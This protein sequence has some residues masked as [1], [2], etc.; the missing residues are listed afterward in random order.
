MRARGYIGKQSRR[1]RRR[2]PRSTMANPQQIPEK[3]TAIMIAE[4]GG[5]LVLRPGRIALP[6]PG[7]GEVL[8]RVRAAGVNRPDVRQRT[9]AHA[10]SRG[11]S[12]LPGLEASGEIVAL[13]EGTARWRVGDQVCALTPGG[14]YAEYVKVH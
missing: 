4:P 10:P 14:G 6:R 9:G 2:A 7:A 3:M 5:P 1:N 8:S 12:D 11:A 13:G